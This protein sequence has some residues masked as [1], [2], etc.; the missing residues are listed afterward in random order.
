[1][2]SS[3]Y[4]LFCPYPIEVGIHPTEKLSLSRARKKPQKRL[5]KVLE[6]SYGDN[7]EGR[8]AEYRSCAYIRVWLKGFI[9][10]LIQYSNFGVLMNLFADTQAKC[11]AAH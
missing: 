2:N 10:Q 3:R 4:D 9:R 7:C 11:D 6:M 5:D 8:G 1:M